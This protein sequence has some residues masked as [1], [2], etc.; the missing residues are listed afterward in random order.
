MLKK[1]AYAAVDERSLFVKV[2]LTFNGDL[3]TLSRNSHQVR[4]TKYLA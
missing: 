4:T 1:L 3:K 2:V